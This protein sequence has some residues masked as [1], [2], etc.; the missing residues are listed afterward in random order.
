MANY[1]GSDGTV[2]TS[3]EV[4]KQYG[5]VVPDGVSSGVDI[6]TQTQQAN[7]AI[8]L[9]QLNP[10]TP[11][12][13]PPPTPSVNP[14][15]TTAA[16]AAATS[17]AI[18]QNIKAFFPDT[19]TRSKANEMQA[20]LD[21]LL[22]GLTGRG[23]AQLTAEQDAGLPE[24]KKSLSA[25]NSQILTQV[26]EANKAN[27]AYDAE[28]AK[29]ETQP[30]MLTSIATGQQGA[31]RKLQLAE[32]NKRSSDI[33][34]LQ[35]RALGLQGEVQAAQSYIDRAID[36]RYQD[37]EAVVKLKQEQLKTLKENLTK[38]EQVAK[39]LLERKY[40]EEQDKIVEEKAKAKENINLAFS[41]N[42]QTKYANKGGEWF[43]VSDGHSFSTPEE[44]LKDAGTNS[45]D[46][47]YKTGQVTDLNASRVADIEFVQQLRAKYGDAD[48]NISDT[49]KT[50][51]QKLQKSRLFQEEFYHAPTTA[52]QSINTG[53]L[54]FDGK[55]IMLTNQQVDNINPLV[56]AFNNNE[57]V[58]NYNVVN[59]QVNFVKNL[60][61]TPTDDQARIYAFAKVM[62]PNSAVREGEYK[63][64][65]EY[66]T[67]L[68]QRFGLQGKRIFTNSGILTDEAR[69]FLQNTLEKRLQSF[70]TSYKQNYTETGRRIEQ[71]AGLPAGS[72]TKFLNNYGGTYTTDG[73][74]PV[75]P[76]PA[77][78]IWVKEKS[79]GTYGSIPEK[80]YDSNKY[81]KVTFN[82]VGNTS[83][84]TSMRTDRHNN[85]TA[86][87]TDIAKLA[88]LKEGV[89]YTK[90][91]SFSNGKYFTAKLLGDPVAATIKVIDKI[92]F[93]T[94]SGGNRWSYTDSIPDT[95]RWNSLTYEQKKKVV[96]QM[97]QHEGGS[98]LRKIFV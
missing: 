92:G 6:N 42:V 87:T 23:E 4:A 18:D 60:G 69:T 28:I 61:N 20:S 39:T 25:L 53:I 52:T 63:T 11:L 30:G 21:A 8:S 1:T 49:P 26:A 91:D 71:I 40:K 98:A 48:I 27:A 16:G 3:P 38:E 29:I 96:A 13:L 57:Q 22:P 24:L 46:Q 83:A 54:G 9:S 51:R 14:L 75:G 70:E 79:T 78:E 45:F 36:L 74:K 35:A 76:P 37:R 82:S 67:A 58:K 33:N 68:I 65:Q 7:Q 97:Y 84:S 64:V 10:A 90:G 47:L 85:P 56:T 72:G 81:E 77:G 15:E 94:S 88:G 19:E 55:P 50:A 73:A 12:T 80:E 17:K 62:D 93:K 43:R 31:V 34:L 86:F 89:D 2:Y 59:E 5:V 66:S 95:K 32:A 44:L 41:A